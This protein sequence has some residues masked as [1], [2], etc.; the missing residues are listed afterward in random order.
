MKTLNCRLLSLLLTLGLV[1]CANQTSTVSAASSSSSL[2]SDSASVSTTSTATSSVV[3]DDTY[4]EEKPVMPTDDSLRQDEDVT[5]YDNK[6]KVPAVNGATE[7]ADPFIYRFNGMYYLYPTTGGKYVRGYKSRDL[8]TWEP[9]ENGSLPSGIVY[10]YVSDSKAPA[11]QTPFAP[12][13]T[14]FNGTFYM[15]TSPSGSGHYV[16]SSDSPEGP[17][18]CISSNIGRNIDG[19]FFIDSD[20]KIYLFGADSGSIAAYALN[21]DFTTF[22]QENGEEKTYSLTNCKLGNWNEGPYMLKHNGAYYLTYCGAHYLSR[23]YRVDYAYGQPGGNPLKAS[24]YTRESTIAVSTSDTFNS[25][26]HSCTVLGP[27]LDSYYLCYHDMEA[28]SNRFL[29]FSRLSF[30]GSEMRANSVTPTEAV[31]LDE[32]PFACEDESG[33]TAQG[34]FLLSPATEDTFSVEFNTIGEG[35]M[36]FSYLDDQ[37]YSYI[38]FQNNT[39]KVIKVLAGQ[40]EEKLSVPLTHTFD[41]TVFHTFRLQYRQGKMNL[42][43]DSMEKAY[44][45]PVAFKGGK[46]G[47]LSHSGFSQ[48]GYTSFSNVAL[49]SSDDSYASDSISLANGYDPKLSYLTEGSKLT[50]TGSGDYVVK[51]SSNLLIANTGDMAT[52]HLYARTEGT[53]AIDLRYPVSSLGKKIG[54]RVDG[55][56]V[57]EVTL[58]STVPE[59]KRGDVLAQVLEVPL[60]QGTHHLTLTNVGDAFSY[61]EIHYEAIPDTADQDLALTF[62]TTTDLKDYVTRG[63]LNLSAKGIDTQDQHAVGVL[64]K[65]KFRSRTYETTLTPTS[66][67][68]SGFAG[69]VL[70]VNDYAKNYSEDADSSDN[71]DSFH[72]L[73][74]VVDGS[75]ASVN[76]VDY[77]FTTTYKSKAY[78]VTAGKAL[79]LKV[80]AE[81]NH[82]QFVINDVLIMD[83]E[84]NVM[85]LQGQAGV[86]ASD[87]SVTIQDFFVS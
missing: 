57:R 21:D 3:D 9:V 52:Y 17:F 50:A 37:N 55:G 64:T 33:L 72:G 15:V 80:I 43:F 34:D 48:I 42:Y 56:A 2:P 84:A 32:A 58:S 24:T 61:S 71:R 31:G 77:N 51:D 82:Y 29:N 81:G 83:F 19:S 38:L 44:D 53:Y 26:G 23:N 36:I 65:S 49:G 69:L 28:G 14:Y 46:V 66:F 41:T 22:T 54:L 20:E 5:T 76:R 86:F 47:Y 67:Q 1:S 30:N 13:V 73:E 8:I 85:D 40:E 45:V 6:A 62:K 12:E 25:L 79:T 16:L 4:Q 59:Y 27:D 60:T 68:S 74:F 18:T 7:T 63:D 70:N 39:I 10:S 35:K 87:C 11:D 78:P 75:L